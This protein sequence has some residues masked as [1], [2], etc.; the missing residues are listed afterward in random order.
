MNERELSLRVYMS[1]FGIVLVLIMAVMYL[2]YYYAIPAAILVAFGGAMLT[3]KSLQEAMS[4]ANIFEVAKRTGKAV[5]MSFTPPK[6][7]HLIL[8]DKDISGNKVTFKV[9]HKG[10][11]K[12]TWFHLDAEQDFTLHV[13]GVEAVKDG[14]KISVY[15]ALNNP[16]FA[17]RLEEPNKQ[18][19]RTHPYDIESALFVFPTEMLTRTQLTA[20]NL[21]AKLDE[22]GDIKSETKD[23]TTQEISKGTVIEKTEK[24]QIPMYSPNPYA[25]G[26]DT[27]KE[28]SAIHRFSQINTLV[29]NTREAL[30]GVERIAA[31][32]I[33][34]VG[35]GFGGLM[36]KLR[37][38]PAI[39]IAILV[40]IPGF[41]FFIFILNKLTGGLQGNISGGIGAGLTKKLAGSNPFP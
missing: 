39:A 28:L 23:I 8:A 33:S 29:E 31:G 1:Y 3:S 35:G 34:G 5:I 36:Q 25:F 22:N 17:F 18:L 13:P 38:N 10:K 9:A 6:D 11:L 2:P 32:A 26:T 14:K 27:M 24:I 4:R 30:Q 37:K 41:I 40:G 7:L 21:E 20:L 16:E 12:D 19:W 15:E